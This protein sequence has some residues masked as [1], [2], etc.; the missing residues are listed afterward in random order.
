MNGRADSLP[1]V[2]AGSGDTTVTGIERR[3]A[4]AALRP[5]ETGVGP[6]RLIGGRRGIRL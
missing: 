3:H 5:I 4:A 2:V 1:V 6:V